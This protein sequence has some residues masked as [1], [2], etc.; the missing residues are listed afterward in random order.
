M[1]Q[2]KSHSGSNYLWGVW[3]GIG[4]FRNKHYCEGYMAKQWFAKMLVRDSINICG[5]GGGETPLY[6]FLS[7]VLYT[8]TGVDI[9]E[10]TSDMRSVSDIVRN[11]FQ[12]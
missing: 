8:E 1:K 6:T 2:L 3:I 5:G 7:A 4:N 9:L 12:I 10:R 11:L